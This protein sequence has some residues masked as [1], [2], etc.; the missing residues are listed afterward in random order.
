M[1]NN[2]PDKTWTLKDFD[3]LTWHDCKVHAISFGQNEFE[4]S[5]DIDFILEWI[6]TDD[7]ENAYKFLIA[8]ATLTFRN[9][10]EL[11]INMPTVSV[12]IDEI[13]KDNPVMA[14]NSS[15]IKEDLEY[16]WTIETSDGE[17]SFKSVGFTQYLR[18]EPAI[19]DTP[20]LSLL[21]RGG[22]CF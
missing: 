12:I 14:R 11:N 10:Y 5:F 9:V 15:H 19:V 22:V 17:L 18:K 8:P 13:V 7:F 20:F 3:Q 21:A 2:K 16:D 1:S 4:I 6:K